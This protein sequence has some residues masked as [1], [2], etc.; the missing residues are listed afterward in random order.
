MPPMNFLLASIESIEGKLF[1]TGRGFSLQCD[2]KTAE[3]LKKSEDKEVLIGVRPG[4]LVLAPNAPADT[5]IDIDVVISEYIG[6]QS[7]LIGDCSGQE[8]MVELNSDTPVALGEKLRFGVDFSD[9]HF[10]NVNNDL[11]IV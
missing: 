7:V 6:A 10:F 3:R 9:L 2:S 5:A 8:I 11:A 1:L 4:N